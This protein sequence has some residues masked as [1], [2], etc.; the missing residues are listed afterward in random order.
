MWTAMK[1]L[2]VNTLATAGVTASVEATY[3]DK[4][5]SKPLVVISPVNDSE[6]SYSFGGE[7]GNK[8]IP[9]VVTIYS[10]SS[11]SMDTIKDLLVTEFKK[12]SIVGAHFIGYDTDYDFNYDYKNP[13]H[14]KTIT[15]NYIK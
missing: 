10:S 15:V 12:D 7:Q 3:N 2:I 6:D 13:V 11:L 14:A 4:K 5:L 9:V 8:N 1:T